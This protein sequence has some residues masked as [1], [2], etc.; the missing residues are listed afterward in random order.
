MRSRQLHLANGLDLYKRVG[1]ARPGEILLELR[2]ELLDET[3]SRHRGSVAQRTERSAHHV[4]GK[5]LDIVDVLL[6]A[7]AGVE[8]GE[9]LFEPVRAF[10][11]GNAPAAAF[12]LVELD[13][14]QRELDD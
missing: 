12:V 5:V 1:N 8:A 3:E 6:R 13:R 7:A 4:L 9:R 10:P 14:P 2:P 11:A